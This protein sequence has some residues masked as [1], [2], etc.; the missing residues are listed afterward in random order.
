VYLLGLLISRRPDQRRLGV[1]LFVCSLE[2][3]SL[4]QALND[5]RILLV[6]H[7]PVKLPELGK[8]C[9]LFRFREVGAG[10]GE[11]NLVLFFDMPGVEIHQGAQTPYHLS[12]GRDV[13]LPVSMVG[14]DQGPGRCPSENMFFNQFGP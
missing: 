11:E 9:L 8:Q 6:Y 1:R 7:L 13:A 3:S 4:F 5:Q 12:E 2:F 10:G 14:G